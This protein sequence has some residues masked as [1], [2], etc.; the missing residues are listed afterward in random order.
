M[1][2]FCLYHHKPSLVQQKHEFRPDSIQQQ[3]QTECSPGLF[4]T[5]LGNIQGVVEHLCTVLEPISSSSM[6]E[7]IKFM[8]VY[9][10]RFPPT[11]QLTVWCYVTGVSVCKSRIQPWAHL[12]DYKEARMSH[13]VFIALECK[14]GFT[15]PALLLRLLIFPCPSPSSWKKK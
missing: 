13:H 1:K 4:S 5:A 11:R 9:L 3:G 14:F 2:Y 8:L 7:M 12:H 10:A 15:V 6:E